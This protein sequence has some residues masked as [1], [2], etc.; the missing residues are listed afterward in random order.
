MLGPNA[1]Q[2]FGIMHGKDRARRPCARLGGPA[3]D[4]FAGQRTATV[5]PHRDK[6]HGVLGRVRDDLIGGVPDQQLSDGRFRQGTSPR[7]PPARA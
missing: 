6:I 2:G 3:A 7:S 4:D 5:R 1:A